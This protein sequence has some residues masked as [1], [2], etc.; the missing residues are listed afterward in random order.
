MRTDFRW[1]DCRLAVE[2]DGWGSHAGRAAFDDDADRALALRLAGWDVLRF[3]HRQVH[4]EP[5][6]VLGAV[7]SALAQATVR[8]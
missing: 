1:P 3:T 8:A 5:A 7:D 2:V 4:E 6:R